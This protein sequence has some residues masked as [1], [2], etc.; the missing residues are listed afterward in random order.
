MTRILK[1]PCHVHVFFSYAGVLLIQHPC[2]M[3]LWQQA[4]EN[5]LEFPFFSGRTKKWNQFQW[6]PQR[7]G[8]IRQC[9]KTLYPCSSH[10]NSWDLWMFIPLKMYLSVLIHSQI[11]SQKKTHNP[12]LITMGQNTWWH[13]IPMDVMYGYIRRE[14]S[15]CLI[16]GHFDGSLPIDCC[17]TPVFDG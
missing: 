17:L 16:P 12:G 9:V 6:I 4:F 10:Q 14:Q 5:Y 7:N 2:F 8:E 1:K 15:L 11:T 3:F 13:T